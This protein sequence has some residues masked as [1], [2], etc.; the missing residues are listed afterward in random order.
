MP[1]RARGRTPTSASSAP[2]T[3]ARAA[4]PSLRQALALEPAIV[5]TEDAPAEDV[6]ATTVAPTRMGAMALGSFGALALLLAAVGLYGVI[7]Y[8]VSRRTR[9]WAF[10]WPSAPSAAR[11]CGWC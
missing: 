11:W 5:F 7:A 1:A 6:A 4:L 8:S 10:A 2:T 3:P 9:R